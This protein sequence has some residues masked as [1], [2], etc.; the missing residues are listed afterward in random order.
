MYH[1][2]RKSDPKDSNNMDTFDDSI[3]K[4]SLDNYEVNLLHQSI[5]IYWFIYYFELFNVV[6]IIIQKTLFLGPT[7]IHRPNQCQSPT[8]KCRFSYKRSSITTVVKSWIELILVQLYPDMMLL[9]K[10]AVLSNKLM[11]SQKLILMI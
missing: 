3:L 5:L 1:D 10:V 4:A 9:L 8:W 2:C 11:L 6:N 7:K